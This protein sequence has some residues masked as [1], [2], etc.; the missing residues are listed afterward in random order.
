MYTYGYRLFV[1]LDVLILGFAETSEFDEEIRMKAVSGL[2]R[3]RIDQNKR[4]IKSYNISMIER[5][6]DRLI[7]RYNYCK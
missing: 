4:P 1:L 5:L 3:Y 6:S 7:A 2:G